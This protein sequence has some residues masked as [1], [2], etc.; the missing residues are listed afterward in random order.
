MVIRAIALCLI[1]GLTANGVAEAST[2]SPTLLDVALNAVTT[3]QVDQITV[4]R[5]DRDTDYFLWPID[6]LCA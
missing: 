2:K 3:E 1:L 5:L 4:T 6:G